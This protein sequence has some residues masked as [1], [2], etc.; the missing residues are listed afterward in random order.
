[1]EASLTAKYQPEKASAAATISFVVR[2]FMLR[3]SISD[4]V[5]VNGPSLNGLSLTLEKPRCF[6]IDYDVPKKDYEFKSFH[7]LLLGGKPLNLSYTRTKSDAIQ[8]DARTI[9]AGSLVMDLANKVSVNHVPEAGIMKLGYTYEYGGSTT[10]EPSYDVLKNSFELAVSHRVHEDNVLRATFDTSS[11]TLGV[12]LSQRS[13]LNGSLK[14][15]ASFNLADEQ[16][17][18]KLY[19][20]TTWDFEMR[21]PCVFAHRRRWFQSGRESHGWKNTL[22]PPI[23]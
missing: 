16:K 5:V 12:E 11:K 13:K 8:G 1:M 4:A 7:N 2:D 19:A 20:E 17:M 3:A 23:Y 9:L 15:L 10:F 18:P 22:L 21:A 6:A 14:I